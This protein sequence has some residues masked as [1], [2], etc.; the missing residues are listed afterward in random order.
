MKETVKF[1]KEIKLGNRPSTFIAV[2]FPGAELYKMAL[3]KGRIKDEEEYM[4]TLNKIT[5]AD[6]SIN[7]TDMPDEE[8]AREIKLARREVMLY[9]YY[10]KP[11]TAVVQLFINLKETGFKNTINK[12]FKRL[13]K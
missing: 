12:I 3:E 7:L 8:A 6:P 9:Y 13:K 4:M 11:W 1:A 5:P 2:A 10:R